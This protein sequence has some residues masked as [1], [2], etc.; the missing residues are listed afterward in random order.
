MFKR[1]R[2][3]R[4]GLP[5][6]TK[7]M[8]NRQ[9]KT[10]SA[11]WL[12]FRKLAWFARFRLSPPSRHALT[13]ARNAERGLC[14]EESGTESTRCSCEVWKRR[15]ERANGRIRRVDELHTQPFQRETGAARSVH[16][17]DQPVPTGMPTLL[18]QFADE[19]SHGRCAGTYV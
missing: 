4:T 13:K 10:F 11:I 18:Q 5:R 7:W 1:Q 19:R 12:N 14:A 16:R 2:N 3:W 8:R 15:V 6:I 17:G 9:S